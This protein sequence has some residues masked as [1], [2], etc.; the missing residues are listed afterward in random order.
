MTLTVQADP[1]PLCADEHGVLRVGDSQVLLDTLIEEYGNGS[2]PEEIVSAYDTLEVADVYATIAY[3]LRHRKEVDAYL[4]AR[5]AAAEQ[6]WQQIE[7][8]QPDRADL[9][10][11]LLARHAQR[12]PRDASP[13]E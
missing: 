3:Y 2:T 5:R 8:R 1:L 7:A 10:A 11:R 13:R 4:Q 12:E 9:R 6:R